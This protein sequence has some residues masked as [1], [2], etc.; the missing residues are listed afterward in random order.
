MTRT[1]LRVE[2]LEDRSTPTA[3]PAGFAESPVAAG[4]SQPT[5]MALSPDGIRIYVAEQTGALRVIQNG[6]LLPTPFVSLTVDSSGE[7]GLLGVAVDPNFATN[8]FI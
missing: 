1:T 6:T 2:P 7:R 5:A 8:A 3:L 4:L